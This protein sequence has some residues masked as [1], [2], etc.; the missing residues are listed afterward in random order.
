[1]RLQCSNEHY[2]IKM[3]INYI[4]SSIIFMYMVVHKNVAT[5]FDDN[6]TVTQWNKFLQCFSKVDLYRS[7]IFQLALTL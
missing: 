3:H 2:G 7:V 5:C 1:M 6:S 4:T